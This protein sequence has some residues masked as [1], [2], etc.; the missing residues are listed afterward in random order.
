MPIN[1]LSNSILT[2]E[3]RTQAYEHIGESFT[4]KCMVGIHLSEVEVISH[5]KEISMVAFA[6]DV[7]SFIGM[8]TLFYHH[9]MNYFPGFNTIKYKIVVD[10]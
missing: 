4:F 3:E 8:W 10:K 9:R 1:P 2:D 6:S 5:S 7:S